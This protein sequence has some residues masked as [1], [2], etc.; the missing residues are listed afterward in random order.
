MNVRV[1]LKFEDV[2]AMFEPRWGGINSGGHFFY[3]TVSKRIIFSFMDRNCGLLI[4]P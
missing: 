4:L 1:V 3:V 2:S